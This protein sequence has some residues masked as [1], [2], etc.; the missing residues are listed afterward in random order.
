MYCF[1]LGMYRVLPCQLHSQPDS[2]ITAVT[3]QAGSPQFK[4]PEM[5]RGEAYSFSSG[6]ATLPYSKSSQLSWPVCRAWLQVYAL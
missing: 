3:L 5:W 2:I 6:G 1:L 4:A